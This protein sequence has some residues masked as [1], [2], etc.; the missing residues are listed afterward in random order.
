MTMHD[1]TRVSAGTYHDFHNSWITHLKE[2]L[3][4]GVL[5]AAY[6][7]LGE[8]RAGDI[9]PDVVTLRTEE[10][11]S[12]AGSSSPQREADQTGLIAVAEAPPHV[13][14]RQEAAEDIGF[15][16]KK[17]R[18]LVVRQAS[19][20]RIVA[21]MEILSPA[22]KHTRQT[23][24]DFVDK[25]LSALR[26]GVHVLVVD[27]MP[28][29]RYDPDGIHG[30]VWDRLLA[31]DYEPPDDLSLTLVSYRVRNPITAYVEPIRVGS[32]LPDM[33]LFLTPEHYVPVPLES[34]YMQ[35]WAGVPNRWRRVIEG[36]A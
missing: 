11:E 19:G 28:P 22:N 36:D 1:W 33:P 8:Q 21:L 16:L 31:G 20:D 34:T 18:T 23:L 3:N 9:G 24:D 7:V 12:D 10:A 6:Y 4:A 15:Y 17:R 29:S 2:A 30:A 25:V 5:P 35:A 14:I 26:E 32:R 13:Q 27:P